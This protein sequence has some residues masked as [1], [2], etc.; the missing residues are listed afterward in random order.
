M[1]SFDQC[2]HFKTINVKL[3]TIDGQSKDVTVNLAEDANFLIDA[4]NYNQI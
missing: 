4:S 2:R 3:E 1:V